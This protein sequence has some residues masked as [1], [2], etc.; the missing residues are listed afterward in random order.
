MFLV[1]S[2]PSNGTT[3][4]V[5]CIISDTFHQMSARQI[6]LWKLGS[7]QAFKIKFV[8]L[9]S[10]WLHS[11][12]LNWLT[13]W[14]VSIGFKRLSTMTD[15]T[16]AK[17]HAQRHFSRVAAVYMVSISRP[18]CCNPT[19][20]FIAINGMVWSSMLRLNDMTPINKSKIWRWIYQAA[21][22]AQWCQRIRVVDDEAV[23]KAELVHR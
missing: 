22:G 5:V 13:H 1:R 20:L 12:T 16:G 8:D 6:Y 23:V 9:N 17:N 15:E 19:C 3:V 2:I 18:S 14:H 4:H 7:P 21:T 10:V 11:V